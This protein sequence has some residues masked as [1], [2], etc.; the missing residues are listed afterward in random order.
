MNN[1]SVAGFLMVFRMVGR[2]AKTSM[3]VSRTI[4]NVGSLVMYQGTMDTN[5][6]AKKS[7]SV[8]VISLLP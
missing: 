3:T 5:A 8:L 6:P 4:D 7:L 1:V 2:K